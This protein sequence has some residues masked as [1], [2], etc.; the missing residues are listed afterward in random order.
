[1]GRGGFARACD[2]RA[3]WW[4]LVVIRISWRGVCGGIYYTPSTL[5]EYHHVVVLTEM[6][7]AVSG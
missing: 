1:M 6:V 5:G 3:E 4:D 2:V 7:F